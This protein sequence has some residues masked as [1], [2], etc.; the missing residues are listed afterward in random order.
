MKRI[1]PVLFVLSGVLW[2]QGFPTPVITALNP[3]SATAGSPDLTLTIQGDNLAVAIGAV[4]GVLTPGTVRWNTTVLAPAATPPPTA[5]QL[6]VIVPASLLASPGA[7]SITVGFPNSTIS[8]PATFIIN[9]VPLAVTTTSLPDASQAVAYSQTL[10][11]SG[12]MPP[13]TW[14]IAAGTLP[15]GLTLNA[16]TGR[17]SGTPTTAGAYTFTARV[18]DSHLDLVVTASQALS[19]AVAGPSVSIEGLG[20][21]AGSASQQSLT[22][23]L[24]PA[25]PVQ[26]SV[27]L[28]LA[29]TPDAVAPVDDPAVQFATGG[30]EVDVTVPAGTT[31]S[32]AVSFQ[33]GTVAGTITVTITRVTGNDVILTPSPQPS[34]TVR[35]ARSAPSLTASSLSVV[36]RANGF[37]VIVSGYS[38]PREVTQAVFHFGAVSGVDLRGGDVTVAVNSAFSAWFTSQASAQFGS[39][40]RYTQPFTVQGDPARITSVSVTL[41]NNQGASQTLSGNF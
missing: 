33:T 41:S 24:T 37:D 38:T 7:A 32:P 1:L 27:H 6:T 23:A 11:A 20:D 18:R 9:E 8:A 17:I 34:H 13:Y 36:R 35:I 21:T 29:F 14:S 5:A 3:S 19:I 4:G 31:A 25:Y 2:G 12:G 16:T 30:R 28:T 22:I 40:Y 26:L 39:A 15:P 10:A